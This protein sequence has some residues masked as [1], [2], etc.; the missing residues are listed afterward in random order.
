M[1]IDTV[2]VPVDFSEVSL[3]AV[4]QGCWLAARAGADVELVAVTTPRY[5]NV[6]ASALASLAKDTADTLTGALADGRAIGERVITIEDEDVEGRLVTEV[7]SRPKALWVVGSHGRT[8]LGELLFGSVSADLVRDA[9]VPIIVVGRHATARPDADAAR[10]ARPP[11]GGEGG[12]EP[13]LGGR[14][15]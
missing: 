6:T 14:V 1:S 9:E 15:R 12:E 10:P 13:A 3:A 4:D 5:A 11:L 2:I 7:L 8:A